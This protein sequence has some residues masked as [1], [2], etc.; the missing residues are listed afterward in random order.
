MKWRASSFFVAAMSGLCLMA[1]DAA[2]TAKPLLLDEVLDSVDRQYPEILKAQAEVDAQRGMR[3][4]SWSPFDPKLSVEWGQHRD[5]YPENEMLGAKLNAQVPGTGIVADFGW[6]HSVGSFPVYEGDRQT[7]R[8]GRWK[9]GLSLPLLRDLVIDNV[10]AKNEV[11]GLKLDEKEEAARVVKIDTYMRA[12][13]TFWEWSARIESQKIISDLLTLAE[14]REEILTKRVKR[15]DAPAVDLI[16]NQRIILQRRA[17]LLKAKQESL[18]ANLD[19]S[20]FLRDSSKE[21]I[22]PGGERAPRWLDP[23][24]IK[25]TAGVDDVDKIVAQYPEI[26]KLQYELK[27]LE[28][29]RRLNGQ[30]LLPRLDLLLEGARYEGELPS[31]RKDKNE[32]FVG[33]KFSLPLGNFGAR[34]NDRAADMSYLAKRWELTLKEQRLK[35]DL[36]KIP[37]EVSTAKDIFMANFAEISAADRMATAERKKFERGDSNLFLVNA[38]E[39]DAAVTRMKAVTSLL[40]FYQKDLKLKLVQN[41]WIRRY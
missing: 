31:F 7:G 6:D 12:A 41:N 38:R 8:D 25:S 35:V 5:G 33:L 21:M 29:Y 16:D 2:A 23:D 11:E 4:A 13:V 36:A 9:G 22:R 39:V 3:Q 20:V 19:L 24:A 15:G 10:R 40:D 28:V 14:Q 34:G 26:R 18:N 30:S 1:V 32:F 37:A 27:Q 17:Q